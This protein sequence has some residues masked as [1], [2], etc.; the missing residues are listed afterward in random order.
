M[1]RMLNKT[2][3]SVYIFYENV[4]EGMRWKQIDIDFY[5]GVVLLYFLSGAALSPFS[6]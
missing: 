1:H 2:A 5:V 6:L 3:A 4:S